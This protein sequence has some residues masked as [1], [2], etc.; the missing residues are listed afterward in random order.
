M[1]P[2]YRRFN[3]ALYLLATMILGS[4]VINAFTSGH[5]WALTCYQCKACSLNCPL[6]YDVSVY[7]AAAVTDNPDL[8]MS[9]SNLQL[10]LEEAHR[11]DPDMLV[12]KEYGEDETMT[13]REAY[14]KYAN[15][16]VVWVKKLRVKDAAK[17][18]PL[19]GACDPMCPVG[20]RVTDVIRDLKEDGVFGNG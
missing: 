3:V 13:A 2:K 12:S 7:V 6:G 1:E 18:D 5:P 17:F 8:Y 4:I 10:T 20:L 16:T 11:T 19:D 15:D 9:A 14:N